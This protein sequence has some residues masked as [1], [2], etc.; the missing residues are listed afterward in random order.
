MVVKCDGLVP[1]YAKKARIDVDGLEV[2]TRSAGIVAM[3]MAMEKIGGEERTGI[4]CSDIRG[5]SVGGWKSFKGGLLTSSGGA[6]KVSGE[7]I[8]PSTTT[9]RRTG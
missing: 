7:D 8:R 1:N 4:L 6:K 5:I 2:G 9:N 3:A